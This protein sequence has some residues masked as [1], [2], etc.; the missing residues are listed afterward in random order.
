M[1]KLTIAAC[2][3]FIF[4]V[5]SFGQS[6]IV[7]IKRESARSDKLTGGTI[8]KTVLE[9]GNPNIR[10]TL[11]VPSFQMTLWQDGKEVR[12]YPVGVGMLEFPI[13]ISMRQAT[14]IEWNPVWIPP[15]SDWIDASST[16]KAGEIV[17]PTDPRNPLGKVKIPLGYGYLLH[18]AKGPGDMGSLVSHGCIRVLQGDLYDLSEK[19]VAARGLEVSSEQ[20]L[21]AKRTKKT[22]IAQ[23]APAVPVEITYDTI[24][25]EGGKL[26]IYPDVYERKLNTVEN[27]RKEL[28]ESGVDDSRLSETEI[29]HMLAR[30]K[31]R[32]KF[33]VDI[34]AIKEDLAVT[35]GRAVNVVATRAK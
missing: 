4:A 25:V 21:A 23:L 10:I 28:R 27:V 19:I 24:I 15:S 6:Y 8:H 7:D 35:K 33:V 31:G 20:I 12:S 26:N 11:N 13:A 16:V 32:Q 3:S 1:T 5:S 30:A 22:L 2:L 29:K 9:E 14:S 18:Q 34:S 17:L